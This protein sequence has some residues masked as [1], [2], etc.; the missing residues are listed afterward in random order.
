M[1]L[2]NTMRICNWLYCNQRNKSGF[3]LIELL[4]SVGIVALL[5]SFTLLNL[6]N[7][8]PSANLTNAVTLLRADFRE[9]QLKA[10]TGYEAIT[11]GASE[12]GIYFDSDRY[13]LFTGDSYVE[14]S[15]E[16]YEV[17]LPAGITFN[18]SD[19]P[20]ATV[21]FSNRSGEVLNYNDDH[22]TLTLNNSVTQES[23]TVS[24]NKMGV[25][26]LL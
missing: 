5:L 7:L 15:E 3:T 8:I 25:P 14:G 20:L 17:S 2:E 6:G 19:L 4:V 16:N 24:I 12:Y 23:Q 21:V 11:G 1:A 26:E 13:I 18:T 10:M 9:Q 22:H